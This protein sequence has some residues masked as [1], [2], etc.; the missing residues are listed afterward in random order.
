MS[1]GKQA[2]ACA[3]GAVSLE[4]SML[5][6]FLALAFLFS[7]FASAEEVPHIRLVPFLSGFTRPIAC[8]NDGSE[9]L[10]I[11]EQPGR[12]RLAHD[13]LLEP[14]PFLDLTDRVYSGDNECGLLG[15]VFHPQFKNNGRFFVNYTT[16]TAGEI[17]SHVMEF[18]V[19]PSANQ[20]DPKTEREILRYDQPFGNHKGGCV[21]FGPDGMLYLG[22]GDGGSGGD[23][24]QNGQN[25]NT[26]L[27]K[28]LRIDV[29]HGQPYAVPPDNPFVGQPD[30]KPEI[31]AYGLRNPWR[32]SFDRQTKQLWCADVGQDKWEEI[33]LI[34]RGKNYG[35]SAREGLHDFKPERA[36]GPLTDPI[37]EYGHDI[38]RSITGGYVYRGTQLPALQGVYVY[39][40]YTTGK[41]W[42]LRWDGQAITLD[43]QLASPPLTISSFGEDK[44]GELYVCDHQNGRVF[45]IAP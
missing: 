32:F 39:G 41:I 25:L 7:A 21:M 16:K 18:K 5:R 26:W 24:L 44:D 34:E 20:A 35:W 12:I 30:A 42:G 22:T 19:D 13:G 40:D 8:V 10:F 38:G 14:Q 1:A 33:D 23:P 6:V 27:A 11:V 15:L 43:A 31:W 3:R 45:R 28:F 36:H 2:L 37:K 17:Q 29:D 9:R 4:S